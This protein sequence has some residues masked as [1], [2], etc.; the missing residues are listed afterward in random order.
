MAVGQGALVYLSPSVFRFVHFQGEPMSD[1]TNKYNDGGADA[2][3]AV[4]IV[5]IVV[6]SLYLWL[7]GMP[8]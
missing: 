6:F 1:N 2:I 5:S 3:A 7:A 8:H 4:A